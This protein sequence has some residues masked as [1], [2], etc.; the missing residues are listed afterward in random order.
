MKS[1]IIAAVVSLALVASASAQ[2]IPKK[3]FDIMTPERR[4]ASGIDK[5]TPAE[6]DELSEWV[7]AFAGALIFERT[8]APA[9]AAGSGVIE[10]SID[11]TY[12]GWRG[13]TAYKMANGQVWQ[14]AEYTYHYSYAYNPNV[15]IYRTG[16][17]YKIRVEGDSDDPVSVKRLR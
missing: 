13:E 12:E 14:Q 16:S 1:T 17:G 15:L 8:V 4:A 11:G 2:A 10:T 7:R 5:L 6:R 3:P 9:P